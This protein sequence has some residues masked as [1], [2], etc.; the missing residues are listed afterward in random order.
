MNPFE[1][2]NLSKN[3][4][5]TPSPEEIEKQKIEKDPFRNFLH[6]QGFKGDPKIQ[7]SIDLTVPQ[8][9]QSEDVYRKKI[10]TN[11][12]DMQNFIRNNPEAVP[13][14][15]KAQK[16]GVLPFKVNYDEA[17]QEWSQGI[18]AD[19]QNE[20][21]ESF[22]AFSAQTMDVKNFIKT[23][24]KNTG[25]NPESTQAPESK[26]RE[27]IN[28]ETKQTINKIIQ[29]LNVQIPHRLGPNFTQTIGRRKD[30]E[31]VIKN[32]I[33]DAQQFEDPDKETSARLA[34]C[35]L[36]KLRKNL[37]EGDLSKTDEVGAGYINRSIAK[38]LN[39]IL[40]R[41]D[42][43]IPWEEKRKLLECSIVSAKITQRDDPLKIYDLI[44]QQNIVEKI[45]E[46]YNIDEAEARIE[47]LQ[48]IDKEQSTTEQESLLDK[49]KYEK[50]THAN[51]ERY[52][53]QKEIMFGGKMWRVN[54]IK[55]DGQVILHRPISL[56]EALKVAQSA[57]R[58]ETKS[59]ANTP[60]VKTKATICN[61]N[62]LISQGRWIIENPPRSPDD[63]QRQQEIEKFNTIRDTVTSGE[64][65]DNYGGSLE[66]LSDVLKR[67]LERLN[68]EKNAY[69]SGKNS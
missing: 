58:P 24:T 17:V 23:E 10:F 63:K 67:E 3:E 61:M 40:N 46:K 36:V 15:D 50:V 56:T 51:F 26:T 52:H 21:N 32:I 53:R 18:P 29:T 16:L 68:K 66:L 42:I 19:K 1:D 33:T 6:K 2:P 60:G 31:G 59:F 20:F 4:Q 62:Q 5:T 9:I 39:S 34:Q 64:F 37:M 55:E 54:N 57:N 44:N 14:W 30:F 65:N 25:E 8:D 49:P 43:S 22:D 27:Q 38:R 47:K 35:D 28:T 7:Y 45:L 69:E 11:Y 12:Q 41:T 13:D 48:E